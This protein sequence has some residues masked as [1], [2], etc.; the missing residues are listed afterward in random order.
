MPKR[1]TTP[2]HQFGCEVIQPADAELEMTKNT[3]WAPLISL[4]HANPTTLELLVEQPLEPGASLRARIFPEFETG[5]PAET[6]AARRRP[7]CV[8]S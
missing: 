7:L 1:A 8:D 4:T 5:L 6:L 2:R 3:A